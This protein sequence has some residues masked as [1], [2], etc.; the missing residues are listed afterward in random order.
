MKFFHIT[1]PMRALLYASKTT[2]GCLICWN[3]LEYF[4]V[5]DPIW[6]LLTI[7]IVSDPDIHT[8]LDMARERGINTGVGCLVGVLTIFIAGYSPVVTLFAAAVTTFIVLVI[9]VYP[10]NWRLAPSTVIIVVDGARH[11]VTLNDEVVQ[12]GMRLLEI[13]FGCIVAIGLAWIYTNVFAV[14]RRYHPLPDAAQ[15][16]VE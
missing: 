9:D 11:A 3:V 6:A 15:V 10:V 4:G 13:A 12:T 8:T 16:D 2:I 1:N 7:L 14:W 5:E